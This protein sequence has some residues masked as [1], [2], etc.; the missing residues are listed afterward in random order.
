M[1]LHSMQD[2]P[3]FIARQCDKLKTHELA[4]LICFFLIYTAIFYFMCVYILQIINAY[5]TKWFR[6]SNFIIPFHSD[7][8]SHMLMPLVWYCPFCIAGQNFCNMI[9]LIALKIVCCA[10]GFCDILS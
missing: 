6:E 7:L 2:P 5:Y 10:A 9:Y 3:A 8:L 4:R 1:V